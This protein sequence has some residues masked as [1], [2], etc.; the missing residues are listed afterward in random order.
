MDRR[1]IDSIVNIPEPEDPS[2]LYAQQH[3]ISQQVPDD[4]VSSIDLLQYILLK[5]RFRT[6]IFISMFFS[7][8][9]EPVTGPEMTGTSELG[10]VGFW[11]HVHERT[12]IYQGLDLPLIYPG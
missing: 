8:R 12:W 10:S 11:I 6:C 5:V 3:H 2:L 1:Q 4:T 9:L 7:Y